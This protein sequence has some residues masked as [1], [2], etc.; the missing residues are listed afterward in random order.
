MVGDYDFPVEDAAGRQLRAERIQEFGKVAIE[1]LFIAALNQDLV[2]IAEDQG[3]EAI[4]FRLED[5]TSFGR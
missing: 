5:P 4:P 1:G 2:A 3:A